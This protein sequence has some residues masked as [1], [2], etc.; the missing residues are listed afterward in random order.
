MSIILF[1]FFLINV[2]ME[3]KRIFYRLLFN[4]KYVMV[5]EFV[6]F[7]IGVVNIELFKVVCLKE[8]VR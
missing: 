1:F 4:G 3:D 7:F 5:E 8:N 6:K 2:R